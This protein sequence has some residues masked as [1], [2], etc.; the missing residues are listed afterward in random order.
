[1]TKKNET[2]EAKLQKLETLVTE[3]ESESKGLEASM[4]LYEEGM[5][6]SKELAAELE[7]AKIRIDKLKKNAAGELSEEPFEE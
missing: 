7:Q 4:T 1:M 3:L 5:G 6:L 2:F